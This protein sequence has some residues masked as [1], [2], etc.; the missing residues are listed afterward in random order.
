MTTDELLATMKQLIIE[1]KAPETK[2]LTQ[3]ALDGGIPALEIVNRGMIPG[4]DVIGERFAR[5][6]IF[7]PEMMI[8]AKAMKAGLVLLEPILKQSD[9]PPIG[10]AVMGTV[11][12]DLHDIGKNLVGMMLEGAGFQVHNLGV[13]VS[14][15]KFLRA[16]REHNADIVGMSSLLTTGFLNVEQTIRAFRESDLKDRVKVMIGGAAITEKYAAKVGAAGY[17]KDASEA[18]QRAKELVSVRA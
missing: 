2:A 13:N 18:V 12:G 7:V 14:A 10:V 16:A 9:T 5:Q 8:A 11:A 4:M 3:E 15:E 17:G 1:G 6:E